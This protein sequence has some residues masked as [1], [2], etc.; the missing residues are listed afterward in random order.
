MHAQTSPTRLLRTCGSKRKFYEAILPRFELP[1][2]SEHIDV[3]GADK[4][5][6]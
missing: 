4:D 1:A 3:Y 5:Q 6:R 2:F